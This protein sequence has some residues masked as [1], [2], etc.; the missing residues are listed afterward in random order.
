MDV[1]VFLALDFVYSLAY[2]FGDL[3]GTFP[4]RLEIASSCILCVLEDSAYYPIPRFEYPCSYVLI[5]VSCYHM[6][7]SYGL[8]A[9][10]VPQLIDGIEVV[11]ELLPVSV[12]FMPL[13]S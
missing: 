11:V 5:V 4:C 6:V 8:E 12:F 10:H 7:V 13:A 3:V 9:S 1:A 2:N